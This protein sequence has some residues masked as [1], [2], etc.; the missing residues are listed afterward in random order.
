MIGWRI[1]LWSYCDPWSD[2]TKFS[3]PPFNI[4]FLFSDQDLKRIRHL[5]E[6]HEGTKRP[7]FFLSGWHVPRIMRKRIY[8]QLSRVWAA[9]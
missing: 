9:S 4:V 5:I 3:V 7:F 1:S 6:S 8:C 2:E